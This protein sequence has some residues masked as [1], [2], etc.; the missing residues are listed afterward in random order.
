MLA[1]KLAS[2]PQKH[3]VLD[4]FRL[5]QCKT[6]VIPIDLGEM[7]FGISVEVFFI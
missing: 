7:H 2:K 3:M 5:N 1:K 6:Y 4:E